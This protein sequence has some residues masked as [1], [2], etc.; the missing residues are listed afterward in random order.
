MKIRTDFVTNSS[1]SSFIFK[2][3]D[4]KAIEEAI[5]RRLALKDDWSEWEKE[6]LEREKTW[7]IGE[8]FQ[9][10]SLEALF[11]V[12]RWY[13]DEVLEKLFGVEGS[14]D[15]HNYRKWKENLAHAIC[16]AT[17]TENLEK[18]LAAK[19][20]IDAYMNKYWAYSYESMEK[21][22]LNVVSFEFLKK[23][24]REYLED[25]DKQYHLFADYYKNNVE[26][27][28]RYA[29]AFDGKYLG[30]LMEVFFDARYLYFDI[31]ETHYVI[32]EALEEAGLCL[33]ACGH[34]G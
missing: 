24:L 7:I 31:E 34:M 14:K 13:E 25:E 19:C 10:Y 21:E 1:S 29:K 15:Y 18:R 2:E 26:K 30:E 33:Y 8:R 11:E 4:K 32:R 27:I 9:E 12:Y 17:Y 6:C 20:I 23:I 16:E 5:D 3:Y 22:K 28:L